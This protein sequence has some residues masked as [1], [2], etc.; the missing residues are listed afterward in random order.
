MFL[1]LLLPAASWTVLW[2]CRL[3]RVAL[4]TLALNYYSILFSVRHSD[5]SYWRAL[6]RSNNSTA[7][8]LL[9]S[10]P[11]GWAPTDCRQRGLR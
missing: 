5:S 11:K 8:I 6:I 1:S 3:L 4:L 10:L 7:M 9:S 2:N